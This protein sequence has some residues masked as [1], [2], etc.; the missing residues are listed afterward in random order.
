MNKMLLS[1]LLIT[2]P[3]V[4]VINLQSCCEKKEE[5]DYSFTVEQEY[6]VKSMNGWHRPNDMLMDF[7][8]VCCSNDEK[9]IIYVSIETDLLERVNE[10]SYSVVCHN[11][12]NEITYEL[13]NG[14]LVSNNGWEVNKNYYEWNKPHDACI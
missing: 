9:G 11:T 10:H 5:V 12:G 8:V 1:G 14:T 4:P 13:E 7:L 2:V 3:V 6:K